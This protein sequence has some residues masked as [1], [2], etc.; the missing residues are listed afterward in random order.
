M[1]IPH[2]PLRRGPL[3]RLT[4]I[5]APQL[6]VMRSRFADRL[7][8][9]WA[10]TRRMLKNPT[11]CPHLPAVPCLPVSGETAS[12][13]RATAVEAHLYRQCAHPLFG[14]TVWLHG[15]PTTRPGLQH[16]ALSRA[17]AQSVG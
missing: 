14:A 2:R 7:A 9:R 4:P 15:E 6:K 10:P 8:M 1:T 13:P 11:E 17:E 12:V 3:V 5:A 16:T